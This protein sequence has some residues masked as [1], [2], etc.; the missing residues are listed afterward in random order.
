MGCLAP[1]WLLLT[2]LVMAGELVQPWLLG[3]C[4]LHNNK[5]DYALIILQPERGY[6]QSFKLL[7]P[8]Y[9]PGRAG[10]GAER[11]KGEEKRPLLQVRD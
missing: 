1:P 9:P 6:R 3:A 7:W 5:T 10:G 8:F 4:I 2:H 11:Y